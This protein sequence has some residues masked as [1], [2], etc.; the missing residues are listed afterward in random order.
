MCVE[1]F[2]THNENAFRH[3]ANALSK[4]NHTNLPYLFGVTV[5]E[6]LSLVTSYHGLND[7][8]VTLHTAVQSKSEVTKNLLDNSSIWISILRQITNRL[9]SLHDEYKLLHNDMKMDNICLTTTS[10]SQLQAVIVDFGKVC[11]IYKGK[12]YKLTDNEK[13]QYKTHHA[14]IAPDLRDGICRLST[15]S[16]IYSL[17]RVIHIVNSLPYLQNKDLEQLSNTCMQYYNHL[18]PNMVPV[19]NYF[20]QNPI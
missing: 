18:R 1:T 19:V 14:H 5:G 4:F 12:L 10:T 13:E 11:D 15:L 3:E 17:G 20:S 9:N 7:K 8:S 6:E 16:D 2:K